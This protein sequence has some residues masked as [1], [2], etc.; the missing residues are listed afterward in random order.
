MPIVPFIKIA[1]PGPRLAAVYRYANDN[2][3][4]D[5]HMVGL[6]LRIP[7]GGAP[8]LAFRSQQ[9]QRMNGPLERNVN[10]TIGQSKREQVED[11]Y[12]EVRFDRVT[13]ADRDTQ[14][15]TDIAE[16]AKTLL[17]LD[18][19][20]PNSKTTLQAEQTLAGG[21]SLLKVAGVDSGAVAYANI[22][23]TRPTII[24]SQMSDGV[25]G[26]DAIVDSTLY[27]I[28]LSGVDTAWIVNTS[29]TATM[30]GTGGG[31][32]SGG[33]ENGISSGGGGVGIFSGYLT[34]IDLNAAT[35]GWLD[36]G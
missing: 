3:S 19:T 14:L 27:G 24:Y 7:F 30:T 18:G 36:P 22:P 28:N 11:G 5:N 1:G 13:Y 26:G 12:T 29:M 2:V 32:G 8:A 17:V 15:T 34:G 25:N 23:G 21:G 10:I 20:T 9:W 33:D 6:R 16:G 31:S 35:D 4:S